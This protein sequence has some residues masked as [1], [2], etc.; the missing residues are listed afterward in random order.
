MEM[1]KFL[2]KIL[3]FSYGPYSQQPKLYF[4]GKFQF[5][6]LTPNN[7]STKRLT[8]VLKTFGLE[9]LVSS[10][11]RVTS[12]SQTVIVFISNCSSVVLSA[13]VTAISDH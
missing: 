6:A 8:D 10:P 13:F 9:L 12:T 2:I 4:D 11:M 7:P 1:K 5:N 3:E